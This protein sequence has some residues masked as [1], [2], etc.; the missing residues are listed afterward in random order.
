[1]KES[2]IFDIKE[3]LEVADCCFADKD[4]T[5]SKCINCPYCSDDECKEIW[6]DEIHELLKLFVKKK[7]T[8][9]EFEPNDLD[10]KKLPTVLVVNAKL[11]ESALTDASL[12]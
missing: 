6:E 10:D 3:L 2:T 12:K 8:K 7:V 9:I 5:K 11:D 1:M 4:Y